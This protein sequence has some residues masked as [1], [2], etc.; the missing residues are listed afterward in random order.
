MYTLFSLLNTQHVRVAVSCS[1]TDML[2]V[3]M[4]VVENAL[5]QSS[6]T[7]EIDLGALLL[8]YVAFWK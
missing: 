7:I 1:D 6:Y 8:L 2:V 5:N 3:D 4:L